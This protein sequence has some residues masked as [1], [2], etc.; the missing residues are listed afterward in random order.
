MKSNGV[1]PMPLQVGRS[2]FRLSHGLSR[3]SDQKLRAPDV[4]VLRVAENGVPVLD[5]H[6]LAATSVRPFIDEMPM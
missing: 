5:A 2:L 4:V 6:R 1:C 3:L